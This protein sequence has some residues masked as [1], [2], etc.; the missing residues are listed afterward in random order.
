[1]P[2]SHPQVPA[3]TAQLSACRTTA[4]WGVGVDHG[5]MENMMSDAA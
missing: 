1:M 5:S 4:I 2:E 3:I